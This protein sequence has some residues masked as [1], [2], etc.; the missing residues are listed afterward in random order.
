MA[1][2][3]AIG[4]DVYGTLVDPLGMAD[5]LVADAGENA[6]ALARLWREKQLEYAFRRTV[7]GRY[8]D[9]DTCTRDALRFATRQLGVAVSSED[10]LLAAYRSLPAFPDVVPGL[11][12]LRAAGIP[13]VAF[14]NGV[15]ESLEQVLRHAGIRDLLDT[16]VSVDA[17]Q[18]FKPHPTVYQHLA[19]RLSLPMARVWLVSSNP[20]DIIGARSAGLRAAWVQRSRAHIYDTWGNTPDL[21]VERLSELDAEQ[22]T[23]LCGTAGT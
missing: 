23:A 3:I 9:F 22:L 14:S 21:T 18:Q 15:P 20:W 8:A 4:F 6:A 10:A 1:G 19:R 12:R 13:L 16:V 17:V 5:A 11:Q 2:S 7:M